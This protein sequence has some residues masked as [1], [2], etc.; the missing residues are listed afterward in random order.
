MN[1][2][3]AGVDDVD[4]IVDMRV[5]FLTE[6]DHLTDEDAL[7]AAVTPYLERTIATGDVVAWV[8]EIDG[9]VVANCVVTIYERMSWS[10][11]SKEGYVLNM[12]TRSEH[13]RSGAASAIVDAMLE[14]ARAEDMRLCL[15]S[16]DAARGIYERAGFGPDPRYLRWRP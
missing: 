13:R 9:Q 2:R 3:R 6:E 1:L 10:G 11:V 7:R 16:L 15:I 4:A 12:Y 8:V 5:A 14:H